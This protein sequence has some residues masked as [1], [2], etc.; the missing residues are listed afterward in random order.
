M[1]KNSTTV[2]GAGG[3]WAP[4]TNI[5][6]G[7]QALER[8]MHSAPNLPRMVVVNGPSGLGKTMMSTY[9][10]NKFDGICVECRSFETAKSLMLSILKE[11]GIV[12]ARTLAEML[13]QIVEE[14][15]ASRRPLIVDEVDH[16]VET[17]ALQLIRD[18]HDA[19][20]CAVLLIGEEHLPKKLTRTERFHNRVLVWQP[21][22]FASERDT[23]QLARF[24]AP[25]DD[26][27]ADSIIEDDLLKRVHKDSRAVVRRICVNIDAVREFA[28]AHGLKRVGVAEWGDRPFYTGDAPSRR[29]Q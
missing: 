22:S 7:S 11:A 13:D 29:P 15:R 2:N 4:L 21:A 25:V 10:A 28:A 23:Q 3:I 8:A 14:L 27:R 12:P 6:L 1:T 19:A 20:Q 26:K 9:C 5:Q 18:I 24:Y 17:K 16:I